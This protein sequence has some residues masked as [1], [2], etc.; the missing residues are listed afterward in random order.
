MEIRT[1]LTGNVLIFVRAKEPTGT[2]VPHWDGIAA[3]LGT[4]SRRGG[5]SPNFTGTSLG[6]VKHLVYC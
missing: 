6:F 1:G 5:W 2:F 4:H 3:P